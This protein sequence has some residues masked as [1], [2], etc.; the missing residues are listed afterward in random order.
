MFLVLRLGQSFTSTR[1]VLPIN[2]EQTKI[3][4]REQFRFD[5]AGDPVPNMVDALLKFTGKQRLMFGSDVPWTQFGVTKALVKRIERDLPR[6]IGEE[7]VDKVYRGTAEMLLEKRDRRG[8][9]K[10]MESKI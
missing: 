2:E 9:V 4:L 8:R 5:L 7:N 10:A 3:A 6:C 1:D